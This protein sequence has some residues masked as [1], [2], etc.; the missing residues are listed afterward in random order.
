MKRIA[1]VLYGKVHIVIPCISRDDPDG[2]T[3]DDAFT[4]AMAK[5]IPAG[6]TN[7]C[8]VDEG[9]FPDRKYRAAWQLNG[10]S[11]AIDPVKAAAIDAKAL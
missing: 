11:V 4:R 3:E 10:S 5:D 8:V 2:Y 9:A 7:V 6:A 1:Y